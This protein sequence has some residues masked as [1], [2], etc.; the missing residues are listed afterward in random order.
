M[1]IFDNVFLNLDRRRFD[2]IKGANFTV[3]Q[4]TVLFG[5][6]GSGK[7]SLL[8]LI[9]GFHRPTSGEITILGENISKIKHTQFSYVPTNLMLKENQTAFET[10]AYPLKRRKV[11][12][13]DI[14]QRVE[15]A[16]STYGIYNILY[17]KIKHLT[18]QQKIFVALTRS[19]IRE[20]K[21]VLIDD[22]A[23]NIDDA[24]ETLDFIAKIAQSYPVLYATEDQSHAQ[25]FADF[26]RLNI[27]LGIVSKQ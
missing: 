5:E 3:N 15:S 17:S 2:V 4:S 7:T 18:V 1:I 13:T 6:S 27:D 12:K 24:I 9:L 20:P 16:A 11:G 8:K 26:E 14:K 10:V 25:H 23:R 19:I 22:V 21:L